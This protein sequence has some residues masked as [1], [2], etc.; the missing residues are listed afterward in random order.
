M[1]PLGTVVEFI[2][3]E[4]AFTASGGPA[5]GL[6][7]VDVGVNETNATTAGS[8]LQRLNTTLPS[9]PNAGTWGG[10]FT[11]SP[12]DLNVFPAAEF[13]ITATDADKAEGTG[14]TTDFTFTVTRGVNTTGANDV[15]Y[16]ITPA[17]TD[18]VDADDFSP[19]GLPAGTLNFA[20]TDTSMTITVTVNGDNDVEA[21]EGFVV[22]LSGAT[23]G[24]TITTDTANGTIQND[25]V[26]P[27]LR[28]ESAACF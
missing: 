3:Y 9:T 24:A 14:G 8:S 6:T 5:D 18:G 2:S 17:L 22:T 11:E 25:D 21:D 13:S 15:N 12:G 10:P 1:D 4:G 20:A 16:T 26:V 23:G 19:M 7:A 27:K 28:F